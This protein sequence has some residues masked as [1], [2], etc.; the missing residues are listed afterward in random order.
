MKVK[1]NLNSIL[2]NHRLYVKLT[3]TKNREDERVIKDNFIKSFFSDD[4]KYVKEQIEELLKEKEKLQHKVEEN[5]KKKDDYKS[6]KLERRKR[7]LENEKEYSDDELIRLER[8]NRRLEERNYLREHEYESLERRNRRLEERKNFASEEYTETEE[9]N[10]ETE[11][12]SSPSAFLSM[13]KAKSQSKVEEKE[14]VFTE[15]ADII[16]GI[17]IDEYVK[18]SDSEVSNNSFDDGDS[19]SE[20]E[21]KVETETEVGS[22]NIIHGIYIDEY[23]K[24]EKVEEKVQE[25]EPEESQEEPQEVEQSVVTPNNE[26]VH[27]LYIDEYEKGKLT[28]IEK[29]KVQETE[30]KEVVKEDEKPKE[31]KSKAEVKDNENNEEIIIVPPNIRDFI[32]ANQGCTE[33]Y[34]LKYYDKK[35]LVKAIGL[36]KIYVKKGKLYT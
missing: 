19:T 13:V 34:V 28:P 31:S 27:G 11:D 25:K 36:G 35:T 30:R 3:L 33:S 5:Y 23:I 1:G 26:I 22:P 20:K 29:P 2:S 6:R 9:R 16:H 32:K 12:T 15:E 24:T 21:E 14:E 7:D 10:V 17:Y 8:R 18:S 4:R